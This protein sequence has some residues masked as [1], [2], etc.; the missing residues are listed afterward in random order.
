MT[1][2]MES[3]VFL[4]SWRRAA[5]HRKS[6]KYG[7]RILNSSRYTTFHVCKV[8]ELI[9]TSDSIQFGFLDDLPLFLE[10]LQNYGSAVSFAGK[11]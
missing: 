11:I 5:F 3:S 4:E 7:C 2:R 8:D 9:T 6:A 10:Q 1:Y